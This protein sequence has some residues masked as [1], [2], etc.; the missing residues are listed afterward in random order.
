MKK[1]IHEK[2]MRMCFD[3]ALKGAG[4]VS[5]NPMVGAVV[6][7]NGRVV[8][9]GYH[10]IFGAAH[11][12]VN[13]LKNAKRKTIGADLYVNLEPCSH[14][15]KTPPCVDLII[16]KRIKN[17][18]IA[19]RDPNPL[20]NGKGV[21]K[22]KSANIKVIEKVLPSEAKELNAV[23]FKYI[24]KKLPYVAI[25][26]AQTIDAKIADIQMK[27]R[28][29]TNLDSRIVVHRLR[30][31]FDAI[32]VGANTVKVDNPEL[33]VRLVKGTNPIRV[34]LD[35]K[36]ELDPNYKIFKNAKNIP[37]IIF[38][39]KTAYDSNPSK[40]KDMLKMGVQVLP[41]KSKDNELNLRQVLKKL[42]SLKISSVLVEG[43]QSLFTQFIKNKLADYAY[44]F[45]ANKIL[46]CGVSS[47]TNEINRV[48]DKPILLKNIKVENINGNVL[49]KGNMKY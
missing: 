26:I 48:L 47:I 3:L 7:K 32:M 31:R 39:S 20:V 19:T 36:F 30:S 16:K 9:K 40:L 28:W 35:G 2:Y 38:V 15:G 22:L 17:V 25:K 46:G 10:K 11:A 34:V 4:F 23:F 44:I 27:S 14:F 41:I 21:K 5:P 33:T 37:T 18:I 12:E 49:L 13:A 45:I 29:I 24:Q 8:G 1:S 42:Y 43:G 6:V